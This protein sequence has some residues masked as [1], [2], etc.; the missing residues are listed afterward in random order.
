MTSLIVGL[1]AYDLLIKFVFALREL[2][3]CTVTNGAMMLQHKQ[4]RVKSLGLGFE[5][6]ALRYC[7]VLSWADLH[8]FI[9]TRHDFVHIRFSSLVMRSN[10]Q[11]GKTDFNVLCGSEAA[12]QTLKN[13]PGDV[14]RVIF[15]QTGIETSNYY[16]NKKTAVNTAVVEFER[17]WGLK[18]YYLCKITT[19]LFMYF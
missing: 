8:L 14:I 17:S 3:G 1:C 19:F 4:Y 7:V 10:I 15:I 5:V 11:P 9:L 18:I 16:Y 6:N 13:N 12:F 2:V